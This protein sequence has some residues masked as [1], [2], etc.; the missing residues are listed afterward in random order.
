MSG[1]ARI[2]L[3]VLTLAVTA[4]LSS[5]ITLAVVSRPAPAVIAGYIHSPVTCRAPYAPAGT[6]GSVDAAGAMSAPYDGT[7]L[8]MLCDAAGRWVP[9]PRNSR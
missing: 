1:L 7:G 4:A 2:M 5:V 6:T 8:G 3:A 9:L